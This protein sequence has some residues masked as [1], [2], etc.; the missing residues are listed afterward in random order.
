MQF[1]VDFFFCL[2]YARS[3]Q[4]GVRSMLRKMIIFQS[5]KWSSFPY[6]F[7]QLSECLILELH[8]VIR[9]VHAVACPID[10]NLFCDLD[11][12]LGVL[13]MLLFQIFIP[14]W[15]FCLTFRK[16]YCFIC[17]KLLVGVEYSLF[18]FWCCYVF[19]YPGNILNLEIL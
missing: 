16:G 7:G 11:P 15:A 12:Q 18:L 5:P 9:V 10:F 1:R 19:I 6:V 8:K 2:F 14:F 17:S 3:L 4:G 13:K